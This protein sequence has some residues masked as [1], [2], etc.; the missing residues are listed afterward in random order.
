MKLQDPG[1]KEFG[2]K[3]CLCMWGLNFDEKEKHSSWL[4]SYALIGKLLGARYGGGGA[5]SLEKN[6]ACQLG[7]GTGFTSARN[8][9]TSVAHF[10]FTFCLKRKLLVT[11]KEKVKF[12]PATGVSLE[13][14]F[15]HVLFFQQKLEWTF[16]DDKDADCPHKS[17]VSDSLGFI[18]GNSTFLK[19]LNG[20][21]DLALDYLSTEYESCHSFLSSTVSSLGMH[22][23]F[24]IICVCIV[25]PLCPTVCGPMDYSLPGSSVHGISQARILEPVAISYSRETSRPRD[26]TQVSYVS[27][28]GRWIL[29]LYRY[30]PRSGNAGAYS[31]YFLVFWG[32]C[33]LFSIVAAPVYIPANNVGGFPFLHTLSSIY[34]L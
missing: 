33:I 15:V 16:N 13:Y 2:N 31:N 18:L 17:P 1:E 21:V 23:T 28:T 3:G 10:S 7:L 30:M 12:S 25:T 26:R 5:V 6:R 22:V 14:S 24:W 27:R 20:F 32:T 19:K 29:A 8:V 11:A 4:F 34:Y 9:Q